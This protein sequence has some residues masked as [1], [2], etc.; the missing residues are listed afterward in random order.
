L[1]LGTVV[2]QR[3][4]V[5]G[6]DVGDRQPLLGVPENDF[7][8]VCIQFQEVD[9]LVVVDLGQVEVLVQVLHDDR[10]FVLQVGH[11]VGLLGV[12]REAGRNQVG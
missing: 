3:G 11:N 5:L 1:H 7:A 4:F 8:S 6:L 9:V 12:F 10:L 2:Q